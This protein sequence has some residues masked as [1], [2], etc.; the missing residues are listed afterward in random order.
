MPEIK[1]TF[2]AGKMNKDL[3]ERLV[4]NGEYRNAMNIQVRTTD[5]NSTG[6]IGDAGT[7]QNIKG[8]ALIGGSVNT[9][10]PGGPQT[11]VIASVADEKNDKA[12]FFTCSPSIRQFLDSSS[13]GIQGPV[14][15]ISSEVVFIDN[16]MEVDVSSTGIPIPPIPIVTDRWAVID[17]YSNVFSGFSDAASP[18]GL[19]TSFDV[20]QGYG[21]KYRIGM[22]IQALD[23]NGVDLWSGNNN[24]NPKIRDIIGD[25][26]IL[27][28]QVS[29]T[30]LDEIQ[31]F[32][33]YHRRALDFQ[34]TGNDITGVNIIDNLLFWT[35]NRSEPKK[36]NIDRCRRGTANFTDQTQLYI[37][38]GGAGTGLQLLSDVF[39]PVLGVVNND[40][41]PEHLTV[42]RKAP[43][44]APTLEMRRTLRDGLITYNVSDFSMVNDNNQVIS[45]GDIIII[46]DDNGADFSGTNFEP[47]DI[48]IFTQVLDEGQNTIPMS[49][50]VKFISYTMSNADLTGAEGDIWNEETDGA[51]VGIKLMVLAVDNSLDTNSYNWLIELELKKPLFENKFCRFGYRYRYEDGEYSAFSPWSE[52]AFLPSEFDYI[53]RKG[54]NLGMVN[55]L[56]ELTI[57]DF[58]P[59]IT[60][61]PDDVV[62][63]D[64]LFKTTDSP[65]VYTIK[66]IKHG[67]DPEWE[68]F[69]YSGLGNN[70]G[71]NTGSLTITSEMIHRAL[72]DTQILRTW[73]NV[74]RKALAQEIAANRLIYANYTQG[75]NFNKK[76]NLR[77]ILNSY[78]TP[79]LEDPKKSVKSL[80]S[81][82]FGMV[83][84]DEYGRETPVIES[85]RLTGNSAE[86]FISST[87]DIVLGKAFGPTQNKFELKQ[88]WGIDGSDTNTIGW[89][90]YVKYYVKETSNEYYNLVM[91]RW[92]DAEDG[93]IWLSFQSADRN[94]VDEETYLV[95]KNKHTTEV[96]VEEEARYKIIAIENEAPDFIKLDHRIMG[97]CTLDPYLYPLQWFPSSVNVNVDNDQTNTNAPSILM[98]RTYIDLSV[99]E[100]EALL[101]SYGRWRGTLKVRFLGKTISA[102]GAILNTLKT[103][104]VHV[105]NRNPIDQAADD[106]VVTGIRLHWKEP[107]GE[108]LNMYQRF[109]DSGYDLD[110]NTADLTYYLEIKEEVVENKPEFDGRFFVKIDGDATIDESITQFGS[111]GASSY[112]PINTYTVG[113]IEPSFRNPAEETP[114]QP[115]G[116]QDW[117]GFDGD[118][119]GV[120]PFSYGGHCEQNMVQNN[121]AGYDTAAPSDYMN[122]HIR[123]F[124]IGCDDSLGNVEWEQLPFPATVDSGVTIAQLFPGDSSAGYIGPINAANE[125]VIFWE[126]WKQAVDDNNLNSGN[127]WFID[128]ARARDFRWNSV[129]AFEELGGNGSSPGKYYRPQAFDQTDAGLA[130]DTFNRVIFSMIGSNNSG[131]TPANITQE[132]IDFRNAMTAPE[133]LFRFSADPNAK[134]YKVLQ[135]DATS[136]IG[137]DTN[138]QTRNFPNPEAP[139]SWPMNYDPQNPDELGEAWNNIYGDGQ[140]YGQGGAIMF[141]WDDDANNVEQLVH[142]QPY[143][144]VNIPENQELTENAEI[145]PTL[146][147]LNNIPS[148]WIS[149]GFLDDAGEQSSP[150]TYGFVTNT[151]NPCDGS[152]NNACHRSSFRII[153]AEIDQNTGTVL[154]GEPG[155][156]F[157]NWDPRGAAPH[158]GT[159][160]L[161]IQIVEETSE[162]ASEI[163]TVIKGA[164]VWETEPK[165][166]VDL[167]IYYEASDAIP[168]KLKKGNTLAFAPIN[169]I[170]TA[171]NETPNGLQNIVLQ[172]V[173]DNNLI[174]TYSHKV[175]EVKYTTDTSIIKI[176]ANYDDGDETLQLHGIG[177]GTNLYFKH[178]ND[179]ITTSQVT[180]IYSIDP[181]IEPAPRIGSEDNPI[182]LQL[183]NDDPDNP[184][185]AQ[186]TGAGAESGM[187]ITGPNVGNGAWLGTFASEGTALIMGDYTWMTVGVT[188]EVELIEPTGYYEIESKVWQYPIEL[189]WFNC[190][191]YGNGV[192]SDRIRDD[193]N[194]PMIDNG[195]RAS[196]TFYGYREENIS[197]GM[198]YSGLYNSISEVNDLNEFNM[199]EK[200]TKNL[201]PIYGSI[202]RLKTRDRNIIALTEDK[203]LK[204]LANK[205]ALYNADGNSQLI[206]TNRV[207][208]DAVPFVGDYG[209]SRN[210]ES[211]AWDQYR[212][213]FTDKQRGAVLRLSMDG[214]TPISNVGM[215]T[216]FRDNLKSSSKAIGTFDKVNGEYNLTL[217]GSIMDNTTVSFNEGSKGWI[218]FKSF[219]P[220]AGLSISDKYLTARGYQVYEH[221]RD[222][223]DEDQLSP[224]Y[225][226]VINR[227]T[228]YPDELAVND[229]GSVDIYT[230]ENL[231]PYF[232]ESSISVLFN[233]VP[234][235]VKSY[236]T[237]N[238]E[239][240]QARVNKFTTENVT[241]ASGAPVVS[242]GQ[243]GDEEYYNL[244][245]KFG[246][247]VNSFNT[248]MQEGKVPEFINKENK[249]FNKIIGVKTALD[250]L[251]T[252]EFSVQGI[253]LADYME[254]N[255]PDDFVLNDDILGCMDTSAC[256][257]NNAATV[258]DPDNPCLYA[259][260]GYDCDGNLVVE[261]N[262]PGIYT[263]IT[264]TPQVEE[265][266]T[267]NVTVTSENIPFLNPETGLPNAQVALMI[268]GANNPY[269]GSTSTPTGDW[270]DINYIADPENSLS[271]TLEQEQQCFSINQISE[272]GLNAGEPNDFQWISVPMN[273]DGTFTLSINVCEDALVEGSETIQIGIAQDNNCYNCPTGNPLLGTQLDSDGNLLFTEVEILDTTIPGCMDETAINYNL[274]AT[275]DD[276]SCIET[277]EG[278][279]GCTDST[280]INYNPDATTDDG[281][282][283]YCVYGCMDPLADNYQSTFT[284][285]DG[286]CE[287]TD[288]YNLI[289]QDPDFPF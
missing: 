27:T 42:I 240:S 266:G 21:S 247:Y 150:L 108:D 6:S 158:D 32:V 234:G 148:N 47:D 104:W 178:K 231:A 183:T 262:L 167:D 16:I 245:S 285:D 210:P 102:S 268:Y 1:H 181:Y 139:Y 137:V 61:R 114:E 71:L 253:G 48:L 180:N 78:E 93:N 168:M 87:G 91:D 260:D 166:D 26:I 213:Y 221:Y 126:G 129:D 76:V 92:Y 275:V 142:Q 55:D 132:S 122:T 246:W 81:Y 229:D 208:G 38:G 69:T 89:I 15:S 146:A 186:V 116:G 258:N 28:S 216:W 67:I 209:I 284:C 5:A 133:T 239:G 157:D 193:F 278:V 107:F 17:S 232:T 203:V 45:N 191:S 143:G 39:S 23:Q 176:T 119:F 72:P 120:C 112:N 57:K 263:S 115:Y 29:S 10:V 172:N 86:D 11:R 56:R 109:I 41:Q 215:K 185:L 155:V 131:G 19:I 201:N 248:D 83:F 269:P 153:F 13:Q 9:I 225:Q 35:D 64:I 194:T 59:V 36:I 274:N 130:T 282:C 235:S 174:E 188:Y 254:Y 249:W 18:D 136:G 218:S 44:V 49:V 233:D 255:G 117:T 111:P 251:D 236:Q 106:S 179:T 88:T 134:V 8:N 219:I 82:K 212:M 43:R 238:Y 256:N 202:Q 217:T 270:T 280:A 135:L 173:V 184:N 259:E 175:A 241:D 99:G 207:L 70:L 144:W 97:S 40:L 257:Y 261:E 264:A 52:I 223:I 68:Y 198:I 105:T 170:V 272:S 145:I 90:D 60:D 75:Y 62:G 4:P 165:K 152:E 226:E 286:S 187:I 63:V 14:S 147:D 220:E 80:R 100:W 164:A 277:P 141:D 214:L 98:T 273:E 110:A 211:L 159:V 151:C 37:T 138:G 7:V 22:S 163:T 276:G 287:Y 20:N 118:I 113:Y 192:E 230:I 50:K 24:S 101:G 25:T 283:V 182:T 51:D 252:N 205:D 222:I 156:N 149:N 65:N 227:N 288:D 124:G 195:V 12:Y 121:N 171:K 84:G 161:G 3:D 228:F 160:G 243:E 33:F 58:I 53:P 128:G 96:F 74:P 125:T 199:S 127:Q 281:S 224:T 77:Q 31:V 289:V 196:T 206:A 265:G 267:I 250:N 154:A 162:P 237:I 177:I 197:S 79:T 85:G 271:G 30:N 46:N 279:V 189:G 73:D 34:H 200:I 54:Y 204:V 103:S 95:L 190:Y 2:Q 242:I 244:K 169:S 66:S 94:K 140:W 123:Y